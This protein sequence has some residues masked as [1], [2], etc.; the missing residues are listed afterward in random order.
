LNSRDALEKLPE[1]LEEVSQGKRRPWLS[2]LVTPTSQI[3]GT[4]AVMNVLTGERYKL[5]PEEVK[6]YVKGM[7]G[8]SPHPIDP[9][10]IK[11]DL[12]QRETH[13]PPAGR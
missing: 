8:R 10:F 7:Y 9:K 3:V 1:A 12:G 4:Q 2:A 5:V 6:K 11:N 13:R